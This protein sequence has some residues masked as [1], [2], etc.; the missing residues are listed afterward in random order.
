MNFLADLPTHN[1]NN[2]RFYETPEK[3]FY[4]SITTVLGKTMP[5]EKE[6]SLKAWQNSLGTKKSAQISKE[7][8]DKG[9]AVHLLAERYLKKEDLKL[10]EFSQIEISSFNGLK[11]KLNNINPIA[12]ETPLYC[13]ELQVAGRCDCVGEYKKILSIIDYKTARRLKNKS[14]IFD[15]QLQC[16]FYA[17]A[18]EQMYKT[19]ISQGVILMSSGEGFPQEFIFPIVDFIEPLVNRIDEFYSKFKQ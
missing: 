19:P 8:T 15:Y 12:Q 1:I 6:A 16:T 4:P 14:E 11:L 7:A 9:T 17:L 2:M 5:P 18:F 10:N 13:D 3:N